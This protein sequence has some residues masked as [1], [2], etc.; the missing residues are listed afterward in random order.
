MQH[1]LGLKA[2]HLFFGDCVQITEGL[3][4]IPWTCRGHNYCWN[5]V[6]TFLGLSELSLDGKGERCA[7]G[8]IQWQHSL[9]TR[10]SGLWESFPTSLA[11]SPGSKMLGRLCVVVVFTLERTQ[12]QGMERMWTEQT[13][14]RRKTNEL[15]RSFLA[16]S[17]DA[18]VPFPCLT[19]CSSVWVW[20]YS[21]LSI[22]SGCTWWLRNILQW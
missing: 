7:N 2:L 3:I 22:L 19:L 4:F 18:V 6:G 5:K 14:K 20:K 13:L 15:S 8:E 12:L 21:W 16:E 11:Q 9:R 10:C 1:V 17:M